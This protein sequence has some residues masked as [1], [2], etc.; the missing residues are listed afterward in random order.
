MKEPWQHAL[1]L[2]EA[3]LVAKRNL[4]DGD[5]DHVGAIVFQDIDGGARRR[6]ELVRA[7]LRER[8][9]DP[10]GFE[11][12]RRLET[13]FLRQPQHDRAADPFAN[14]EIVS[15][16]LEGIF[17]TDSL[18]STDWLSVHD[19]F[20]CRIA[21]L[22]S[23][24]SI[25][26]SFFSQLANFFSGFSKLFVKLASC[27][28]SLCEFHLQ[29]A[30]FFEESAARNRAGR[31]TQAIEAARQGQTAQA[32]RMALG[33]NR[34]F[35]RYVDVALAWGVIGRSNGIAHPDTIKHLFTVPL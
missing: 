14:A 16:I 21:V 11:P 5:D 6:G 13:V 7:C 26:E 3:G 15:A 8:V 30:S 24:A 27:L 34:V 9:R 29:G 4:V 31:S 10:M 18:T 32:T 35:G 20:S 2:D 28:A 12:F 22:S 25:W 19:D 33:P 1:A 23:F 17:P